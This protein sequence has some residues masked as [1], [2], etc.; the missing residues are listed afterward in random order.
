MGTVFPLS[1]SI[2]I[3]FASLTSKLVD[4]GS[5]VSVRKAKHPCSL[6]GKWKTPGV[7]QPH[8]HIPWAVLLRK[9]PLLL[10]LEEENWEAKR[11]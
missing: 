6:A 5:P 2:S 10:G 9:L 11:K 3:A 4:L 1:G 8:L 7:V